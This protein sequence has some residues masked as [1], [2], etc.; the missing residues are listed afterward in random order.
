M[1]SHTLLCQIRKDF[2]ATIK[3]RLENGCQYLTA[4]QPGGITPL[5]TQEPAAVSEQTHPAKQLYFFTRG[6]HR[7]CFYETGDAAQ[8]FSHFTH[9]HP[10]T[11]Q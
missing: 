2:N 6:E 1:T 8:S 7:P 3:R 10:F 9:P 11:S 5:D 4:H